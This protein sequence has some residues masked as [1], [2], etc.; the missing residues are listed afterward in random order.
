MVVATA[1]LNAAATS[2]P[3]I[4]KLTRKKI[5]TRNRLRR[6]HNILLPSKNRSFGRRSHSQTAR[7]N[8][9][10]SNAFVGIE[11]FSSSVRGGNPVYWSLRQEK[12]WSKNRDI[13]DT[14]ESSFE[15]T[16]VAFVVHA[17]TI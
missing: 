5:V 6:P 8:S 15:F 3:G 13:L 1:K 4:S 12:I 7:S 14:Q 17:K 11:H 10:G 2:N 16:S 9:P